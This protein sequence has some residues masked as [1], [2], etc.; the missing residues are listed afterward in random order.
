MCLGSPLAN[1]LAMDLIRKITVDNKFG[2]G[3]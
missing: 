3:G 2:P 1:E